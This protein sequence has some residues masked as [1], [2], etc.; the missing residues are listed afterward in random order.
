MR[1]AI[2]RQLS[3]VRLLIL[4][5][6]LLVA[7]TYHLEPVFAV[8]PVCT[9]AVGAGL[10]LARYVGVDDIVSGIW[11]GGLIL[12]SSF[13]LSDW[14]KKRKFHFLQPIT[15]HLTLLSSILMY[16]TVFF[17]LWIGKT[18]GHPFNTIYGID[19]LIFGT[20]LGSVAFLLA[21]FWDKKVRK[22]YGHQFF[23]YQKMVFPVGFLVILS[24]IAYLLTKK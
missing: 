11:V 3:V 5:L 22:I 6:F 16:L 1:K 17:P 4:F 12:S 15:S 8:C 18:I 7:I 13:W 2:S 10:G 14:L 21:V 9:V 24:L 23:V 20:I 19:K